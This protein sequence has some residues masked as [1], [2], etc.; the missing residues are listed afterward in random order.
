MADSIAKSPSDKGATDGDNTGAIAAA[1]DSGDGDVDSDVDL[2]VD[3]DVDSDVDLDV[4][5]DGDDTADDIGVAPD[6]VDGAAAGSD[7]DPDDD[8]DNDDEGA[9]ADDDD[10]DGAAADAE[11][12]RERAVRQGSRIADSP[13]GSWNPSQWPARRH[14]LVPIQRN[15][16][17]QSVSSEPKPEPSQT[18]AATGPS[19]QL[20]ARQER[21]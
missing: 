19:M 8:N 20:S 3:L 13:P 14:D 15:S 7:A 9:G 12:S 6:P 21:A 16:P 18:T 17:P 10:D 5:S 1:A 11:S 2:D 4:D